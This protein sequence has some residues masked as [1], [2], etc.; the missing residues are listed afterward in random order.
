MDEGFILDNTYGARVQSEWIDGPPERSR[1]TGVKL[2]GKE[3]LPV[4]TYRCPRCG[5]LESYAPL[6]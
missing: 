1:W 2:K 5:Y 6:A 4:T 3:H